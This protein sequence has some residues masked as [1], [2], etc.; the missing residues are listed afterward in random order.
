M[1]RMSPGEWQ[2][3][4]PHLDHALTL[5]NEARASWLAFLRE[6]NPELA[7]RLQAL[8]EKASRT[9]CRRLPQHQSHRACR[10]SSGWAA[11]RTL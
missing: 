1:S 8:L 3:L 10:A 11:R 4:S 9:K 5:D 2:A 6:Q 7:D